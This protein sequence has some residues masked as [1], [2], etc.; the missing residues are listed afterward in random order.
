VTPV[1]D[2]TLVPSII[3]EAGYLAQAGGG[4]YA[5][6]IYLRSSRWVCTPHRCPPLPRLCD[7]G[8]LGRWWVHACWYRNRLATALAAL[9]RVEV[10]DNENDAYQIDAS[11]SLVELITKIKAA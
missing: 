2:S 3:S 5:T 8:V 9:G 1:T 6:T 11:P 7:G 4:E 10:P